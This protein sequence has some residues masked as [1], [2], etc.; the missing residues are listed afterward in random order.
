MTNSILID[1]EVGKGYYVYVIEDGDNGFIVDSSQHT[2]DEG[3]H[4]QLNK[5]LAKKDA[6][7]QA[8]IFRQLYN[9]ETIERNS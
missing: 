7:D 5:F 9:C 6:E 2:Y 4:E 3:D 1:H 8:K